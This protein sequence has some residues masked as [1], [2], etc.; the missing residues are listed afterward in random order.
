MQPFRIAFS[1][2]IISGERLSNLWF[3]RI[4]QNTQIVGYLSF[5]KFAKNQNITEFLFISP[6]FC[7]KLGV[8]FEITPK[9]RFTGYKCIHY[10]KKKSL[11][12]DTQH[13]F[14]GEIYTRN[15]LETKNQK[16]QNENIRLTNLNVESLC[17]TRV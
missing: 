7:V 12:S 17:K 4:S 16:P 10:N 9:L 1:F 6:F 14:S 5:V 2:L 15:K 11:V 3:L 13:G 8:D